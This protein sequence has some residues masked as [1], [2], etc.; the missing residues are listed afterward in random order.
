M[1]A[2]AT[3]FAR[4]LAERD[5]ATL[6]DLYAPEV[7]GVLAPPTIEVGGA[8]APWL[9]VP[10]ETLIAF[11][12]QMAQHFARSPMVTQ[13]EPRSVRSFRECLRRSCPSGLLGPGEWLVEWGSVNALHSGTVAAG[14][15]PW[16]LRISDGPDGPRVVG[17][18]DEV[19]V[20]ALRRRRP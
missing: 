19:I 6:S 2:V 14:V 12:E 8:R 4:A 3:R 17:V 9:P 10:R 15:M 11:H 20:A 13:R 16:S 5:V 7:G 1:L 18:T